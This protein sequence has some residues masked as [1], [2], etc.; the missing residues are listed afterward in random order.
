MVP[1]HI[2]RLHVFVIDHIVLSTKRQRRLVV[3]IRPLATCR[4]MRFGE[5][6]HRFPATIAPLLAS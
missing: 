2:G 1:D 4:R 6:C 5:H 3:E